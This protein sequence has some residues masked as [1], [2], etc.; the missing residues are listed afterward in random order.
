MKT[1]LTLCVST[2]LFST[3]LFA[4]D[5]R[6]E[7][8]V[9]YYEDKP[10]VQKRSSMTLSHTSIELDD[11]TVITLNNSGLHVSGGALI[12]DTFSLKFNPNQ[13][14]IMLTSQEVQYPSEPILLVRKANEIYIVDLEKELQIGKFSLENDK[15]TSYI[16]LLKDTDGYTSLNINNAKHLQDMKLLTYNGESYI[17]KEES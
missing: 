11:A 9:R 3:Q 6:S 13:P 10:L 8:M 12:L 1:L 14:Y 2:L 16:T 5:A 7:M 17:A 15:E 4:L